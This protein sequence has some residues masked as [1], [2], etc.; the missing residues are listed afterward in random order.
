[1]GNKII[2]EDYLELLIPNELTYLYENIYDMYP[3]NQR[4]SMILVSAEFINECSI[5]DFY[6]SSFPS[7][8]SMEALTP[9]EDTKIRSIRLNP[10][11]NLR[12]QGVLVGIIDTGI[13][14][15][16]RAFQKEDGTSRI[17]SIWDQTVENTT[18]NSEVAYGAVYSQEIL[19]VAL[20]S[21]D[22][23]LIVPSVDET[24]HGTMLAGIVAGRE[25]ESATFTG[26]A[27]DAELIVVKL[28]KAKKALKKVFHIQQ[29]KICYQ[30]SDV[31]NGIRYIID[32]ADN[33]RRPVVLIIGFGTS[34]GGHDG[35]GATSSY[36][37]Y[38]STKPGVCVAIS[39]GNEANSQRHF[40]GIIQGHNLNSEINLKVGQKDKEFNLEIW[41][42]SAYKT[43]IEIISPTGERIGSIF[44]G[45]KQCVKHDFVFESSTVWINN[46]ITETETASQMILVR[47]LDAAEG[48]W[49]IILTTQAENKNIEYD[50]WL[51]QGDL[52]SKDTFFL[53][54]NPNTTITS[55]GNAIMPITF[56]AYDSNTGSISVESGRGNTRTGIM[57]PDLAAPGINLL[58]PKPGNTYE[59]VSGT[60][61][62][63]AAG[64][65][66]AAL[67]LEW[68]IIKK[69]Y[70]NINGNEIKTLFIRGADQ[71]A[72]MVYPNELWGYG[73]IDL[74][75]LF[76]QVARLK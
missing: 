27:P 23:Y 52:I 54:S 48:L 76:E 75:N 44:P 61:V 8:F 28:K 15:T 39:A 1:M 17:L 33:L 68:A 32:M 31:L 50:A 64:A 69:K 11:M 65:G 67:V 20:K 49:K 71:Y 57:K 12:G 3:V 46:I 73:K 2:S 10:N 74:Y 45:I 14:Y 26:V 4:Y 34:Q 7:I 13:D 70:P 30:E 56:G 37:S 62:A 41:H 58:A 40:H 21:D 51:P 36:L 42:R 19:N 55:P 29:D 24:G 18:Q 59:A 6:Y 5:S 63:A 60:S 38:I 53:N 35:N 43:S 22:P 47:F 16:H 72:N 66:C 9:F 25:D